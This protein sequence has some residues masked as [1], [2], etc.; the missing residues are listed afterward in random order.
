M[1]ALYFLDAFAERESRR[2][3]CYQDRLQLRCREDG[4]KASLG[5]VSD[6]SLE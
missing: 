2:S 3:W 1:A 5:R 6:L 4:E